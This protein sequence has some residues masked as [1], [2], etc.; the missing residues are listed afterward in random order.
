MAGHVNNVDT[1]D[2]YTGVGVSVPLSCSANCLLNVEL[3]LADKVNE[4]SFITV[5]TGVSSESLRKR[6]DGKMVSYCMINRFY[7][8]MVRK[9]WFCRSIHLI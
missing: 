5:A 1:W 4:Y 6:N 3:S 7:K 8:L 9:Y 2:T